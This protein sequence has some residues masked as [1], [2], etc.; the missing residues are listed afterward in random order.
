MSVNTL[1]EFDTKAI[2]VWTRLLQN[3]KLLDEENPRTW[4]KSC[5]LLIA[6]ITQEENDFEFSILTADDEEIVS[7]ALE[8]TSVDTAIE[9]ADELLEDF[10]ALGAGVLARGEIRIKQATMN[11]GKMYA[12]GTDGRLYNYDTEINAWRAASMKRI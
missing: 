7:I 10:V 2:S 4:R 3:W 8:A 11:K 6:Y 1:Q 12:I 9:K 5:G